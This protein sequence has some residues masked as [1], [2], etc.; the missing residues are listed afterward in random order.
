M[1][2]KRRRKYVKPSLE[3]TANDMA[4]LRQTVVANQWC[5]DQLCEFVGDDVGCKILTWLKDH[6]DVSICDGCEAIV[7]I[8]DVYPVDGIGHVCEECEPDYDDEM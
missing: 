2:T 7:E 6:G 5:Q 1:K 3:L 4:A 8:G